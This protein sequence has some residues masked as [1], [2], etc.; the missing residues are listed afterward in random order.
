MA[1]V[2]NYLL[3]INIS[4]SSHAISVSD[5][6]YA[7]YRIKSRGYVFRDIGVQWIDVG[8]EEFLRLISFIF[9]RLIIQFRLY[10]VDRFE[11]ITMYTVYIYFYICFARCIP[12]SYVIRLSHTFLHSTQLYVVLFYVGIHFCIHAYIL[13]LVSFV[14]RSHTILFIFRYIIPSIFE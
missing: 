14:E 1:G 12:P 3:I 6:G 13:Y 5:A 8:G 7:G 4:F 9:V 10:V 11:I 2:G